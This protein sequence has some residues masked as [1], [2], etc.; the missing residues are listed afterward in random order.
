MRRY[1]AILKRRQRNTI[2]LRQLF[3]EWL[4]IHSQ[5][6]SRSAVNSY[7]IAFK[8][9]SN[10]SDMSITDIHFQHLQNVIDSM[11]VKGLSYSSCKKVRTVLNQLFNYAI[12]R[13]YPVTNYALHLN[14]GPNRPTIKRRVFTRQQI[15]KLWAIDTSYSRLILI[16][17]YTGLR[18]GELLNLRRQDIN[19]R[20]SY[21]IVRH[22]KTKAGEGRIIPIHHR[23]M[24]IIEQLYINSGDYL[25]TIS[26]TSFRKH[27][28]DIMKQL[29][30]KHTIHDTRHTFASLLD[31]VAPPNDLRSLLGHKQGDIT[32]RVYTHKTI[33][34]L[35]KTI[36]LLK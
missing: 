31:A 29:N 23:I 24:P 13:D 16:L 12:I 34:E 9:I 33:R 20:S 7:H 35:R 1:A 28:Q 11:H 10:I 3:N 5:S 15:N 21:L 2:T 27:F 22:A 4:P 32:T 25:F 8:H 30:C 19:R 36:E 26:Y 18:I 17:L 6:I 14:L